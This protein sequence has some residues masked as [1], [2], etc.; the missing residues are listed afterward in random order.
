MN[1]VWLTEFE[2]AELVG[3]SPYTLRTWRIRG[4]LPGRKRRGTWMFRRRAVI[5]ARDRA[6]AS[7]RESRGHHDAR[8]EALQAL[9][10][11]IPQGCR[12]PDTQGLARWFGVTPACARN[13]QIQWLARLPSSTWLRGDVEI[14]ARAN[15]STA[16][17]AA[18]R[19]L[20]ERRKHK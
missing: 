10:E 8:E 2:A 20:A 12:P 5:A 17:V 14:A 9:R 6:T 16:A 1:S 7:F 18:A 13:W 3:R 4:W 11:A 19:H 15:T